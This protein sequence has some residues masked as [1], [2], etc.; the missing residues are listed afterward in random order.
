M[1]GTD[2]QSIHTISENPTFAMHKVKLEK[3]IT[4]RYIR[5]AVPEGKPR[6]SYNTNDV[7]CCNVAKIKLYGTLNL[8][9]S[10]A[11]LAPETTSG[12][13]SWKQQGRFNYEK[14]FD[15]DTATYFDG[16]GAGWVQADLGEICELDAIAYTPRKG[17]EARMV[18]GYFNVSEDGTSWQTVHTIGRMPTSDTQTVMLDAPVKARYI[19]YAV[20]EGKPNNGVNTD[21]VYCCNIAELAIYGAVLPQDDPTPEHVSGDVNADGSFDVADVVALQR[22]LLAVPDTSLAN[23]KAA[24]LCEDDKLDVFDLCLMKRALLNQTA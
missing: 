13:D 23:W 8:E 5:Y 22:W 2:W 9:A 6:N 3:P 19:R 15:G 10:F 11:K 18:D 21:D 24:D 16:V 12:T 7:Y 17:Y 20:P 14:A 4:A 1:D